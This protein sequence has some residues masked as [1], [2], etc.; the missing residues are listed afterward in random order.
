[1]STTMRMDETLR[2]MFSLQGRTAVV[3]GA[4]QGI[5]LAIARKLSA[6]GA[7]VVAAD[8]RDETV[9]ATARTLTGEGG[10][11]IGVAADIS[12]E[13]AVATLFEA[14]V[15]AFGG[16]DLL[17][18]NAAIYPKA[19]FLEL[20][21]EQWD[22]IHAVNLR[23]TFLCM[24]AAIRCMKTA[25]RGGSIVNISSVNSQQPVIFD[26]AHYGSSKAGVNM[27][28]RTAAL[29]FAGDRI[30]VNAVLPGGVATEGAAQSVADRPAA[31]PITQPGRIPLGRFGEPDDIANAVLFLCAPASSYITG[32]LLAVD[33]GFQVS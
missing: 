33:G 5:G 11:A 8:L 14:A 3:T 22:R 17:V 24:R 20:T 31:G 32:Q 4:A 9:Q 15:A 12:D 10:E 30:R 18:N 23:G 27:L 28:T 25:G 7:R 16:V 6:A 29:E 2:G 21:A 1:M 13:Q 19:P 26:N